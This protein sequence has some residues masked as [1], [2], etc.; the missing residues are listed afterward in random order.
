M[1]ER[2]AARLNAPQ[3][4]V[5]D[6][7]D[8]SQKAPRH[9]TGVIF[10]VFAHLCW[11][12]R[13]DVISFTHPCQNVICSYQDPNNPY[14][15]WKTITDNLC[16]HLGAFGPLDAFGRLTCIHVKELRCIC[17]INRIRD[18]LFVRTS[19]RYFFFFMFI[20]NSEVR[21]EIPGSECKK[22]VIYYS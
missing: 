18:R 10:T 11:H 19:Q 22:V 1:S 4:S 12:I 16:H 20:H 21:Q 6:N 14:L 15:S 7:N 5:I 8:P 9:T 13:V 17:L 3:V 2:V